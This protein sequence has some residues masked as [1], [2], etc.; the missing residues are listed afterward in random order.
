MNMMVP[1]QALS[2]MVQTQESGS[3]NEINTTQYAKFLRSKSGFSLS[4]HGRK[5]TKLGLQLLV[6]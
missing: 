5:G 6:S 3:K 1:K 4:K 2:L